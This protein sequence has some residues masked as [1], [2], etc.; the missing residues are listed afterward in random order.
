MKFQRI[1]SDDLIE[2]VCAARGKLSAP[3]IANL[4]SLKSRNAVIGIWNRN[5]DKCYPLSAIDLQEI[6]KRTHGNAV[7]ARTA[8]HAGTL[9]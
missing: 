2:Q 8:K 9:P 5:K 6:H 7:A 3:E 1:H 4:Y